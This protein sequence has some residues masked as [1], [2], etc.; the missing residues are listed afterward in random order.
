MG[1]MM[2]RYSLGSKGLVYAHANNDGFNTSAYRLFRADEDGIVPV[3]ETPWF[4]DDA[5][6]RF[7]RFIGAA[8]PAE[9]CGDNLAYV[10]KHLNPK[11]GDSPLATI[12]RYFASDFFKHHSQCYSSR[13]IYWLFT[14]GKQGAFKAL[15][16]GHRFNTGTLARIRTEYVVPLLGRIA[17]RI[18][19][20]ADSVASAT[21]TK[22]RK[23][24]QKETDRLAKHLAEVQAFDERLRHFSDQRIE[25]DLNDGVENAYASLGQLLATR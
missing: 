20:L 4:T 2:G 9:R 12:R 14:S 5:A 10:A 6:V 1:C 13:P 22:Q 25:I 21:T 16:Y 11:A 17:G 18:G 8:W 23:E 3:T 19:M 15:V 7:E 24:A